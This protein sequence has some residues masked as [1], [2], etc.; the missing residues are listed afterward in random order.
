MEK[1]TCL[2]IWLLAA[3]VVGVVWCAGPVYPE[4]QLRVRSSPLAGS[5]YPADAEALRAMVNGLLESAPTPPAGKDILALISPHAGY[6]YSGKAAACG[7]KTLR[8]KKV[9]RV[10]ILSPSHYARFRGI[11][12]S[13]YD[14]YETPLGKVTVEKAVG[15]ALVQNDLFFANPDFEAPEHAV[16]MQ[17]PFLQM[18]LKDFKIVPL[19]VGDLDEAGNQQAREILRPYL[20]PRTLLVVSS[21]FTHYG[22][23]FGY[24]PFNED[25]RDNLKKLD[26]GAVECVRKKDEQGFARYL[27]ETGATICGSA[28]IRLLLF[29]VPPESEGKLLTY[30]T[31]GELTND[32]S[33]SVS[34]VSFAFERPGGPAGTAAP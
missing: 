16:E 27:K 6:Q 17:V 8:G 10:L 21:D 20:T 19:I 4:E 5:W 15:E 30:Y 29:L 33:S 28:P 25:I 13:S 26:L 3:A 2:L 34:Y 23:R 11:C 9:D 18:A 24:L 22:R 32:F 7:Y 12:V 31:S 1:L 14:A